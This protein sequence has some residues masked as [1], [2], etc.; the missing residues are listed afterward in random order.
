MI[1]LSRMICNARGIPP[2]IGTL[3]GTCSLCGEE[4][5]H[6]HEFKDSG[7]TFTTYQHLLG[8]GVVCEY[9]IEMR[10]NSSRDYKVMWMCSETE[11]KPFKFDEAEAIFTNP[12]EPPFQMYFTQTWKKMGWINLITRINHSTDRFFVGFDYDIIDVDARERDRNLTIIHDLLDKGLKKSEIITGELS[13]KRLDSLENV[14]DILE[15]IYEKKGD[16]LW[17]LCVYVAKKVK[18]NDNNISGITRTYITQTDS[19]CTNPHMCQSTLE[20]LYTPEL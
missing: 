15:T 20:G 17:N 10:R 16:P 14:A 8:G 7:G 9:C 6:G 13:G 12:P 18:Q 11:F 4:T 3:T 2:E 19:G 5:K 1:T